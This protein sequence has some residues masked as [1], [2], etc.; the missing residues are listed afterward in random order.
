MLAVQV[1]LADAMPVL[2]V[3]AV[4]R[5]PAGVELNLLVAMVAK[6][7]RSTFLVLVRMW[8][9]AQAAA[10]LVVRL[11]LQL[12]AVELMQVMAM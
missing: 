11:E 8:C 5:N 12:D 9:L 4:Q 6:G 10:V 2:A 7:S 1:F 3:V